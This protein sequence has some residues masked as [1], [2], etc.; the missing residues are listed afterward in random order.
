MNPVYV[1]GLDVSMNS[2]GWAVVKVEG[3]RLLLVA[4]GIIKANTKEN[5]GKRLRKQRNEF[6]KIMEAYPIKYAAREAGFTRHIKATQVLFKAY[7]MTEEFF[8]GN[9]DEYAA[10]TIKKVV[11]GKG[12]ATKEEV[13]KSIRELMNLPTDFKFASD[14]ESDAVGVAIT[15]VKKQKLGGITMSKLVWIDEGH[16]GHDSGA[17]GH[18]LRE[19]DVVLKMGAM[20]EKELL[21]KYQ[22]VQVRRTRT[23]DTFVELATRANRAN[24]AGADLFV[25]LHN[26]AFNGTVR[27]F[28]TFIWNG[29]VGASTRDA[30][31]KIH[32]EVVKVLPNS[33]PNRGKKQANFAVLRL[34][35]MS[36]V[37][38]EYLF[39]DQRDDNAM[40]KSDTWLKRM[41]EATAKGIAAHLGLRAKPTPQPTPTNTNSGGL[42]Y[43]QIGAF[44]NRQNAE[45]LE[46]R[47]KQ[48]GFNTFIK[49]ENGLFK[50]QIG[51]FG[52][53]QNAERLANEAKAKGFDVYI[54]R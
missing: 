10:S 35:N 20:L 38:V 17:V 50:V 44:G 4:S 32:D 47:A 39:I 36:A 52:N 28:E 1:L 14:D 18:G 29:G 53:R 41:V 51:A 8:N 24:A 27:G 37:L 7:G 40:L 13:E 33:V 3:D 46:T 26:N 48:A 15:L 49:P 43:V 34:T 11:T 5:H 30:Q 22:G 12:K 9:V 6:A 31:N 23:N 2:T 21:D 54:T 42:F 45:R 25:S 16:G 19:K